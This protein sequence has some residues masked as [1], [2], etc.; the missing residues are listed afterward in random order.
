[1]GGVWHTF[2]GWPR[3]AQVVVVLVL[4]AIVAGA[5]NGG[6][7]KTPTA[8]TTK[9]TTT[10]TSHEHSA[11]T[12]FDA[13]TAAWNGAHTAVAGFTPGAVYNADPAL[14][15]VNGHENADYDAVLH[16]G[17][18]VDNYEYRFTNRPIAAARAL[19]L[20]TEFPPDAKIAWFVTKRTC[21]Q[22]LVTSATVGKHVAAFIEFSSGLNDYSYNPKAVNDALLSIYPVVPRSKAP[23][24]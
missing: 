6:S 4:I 10:T 18:R 1:M 9:N 7:K 5:A 20:Q 24:C 13:T 2:R 17:G 14:P 23:G 11:L 3:W 22:M 19:V 15:K 8:A 12:G 16:E 21:A